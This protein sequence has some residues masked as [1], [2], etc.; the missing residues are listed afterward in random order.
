VRKPSWSLNAR[1]TNVAAPPVSGRAAVPSAYESATT[2]NSTP[3]ASKTQGVK[4]S[5]SSATTPSAKKSEEAISPKATAAS[6]GVS[7]TR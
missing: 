7:R 2:R 6:E 1:L 4:P 3:T 5:A